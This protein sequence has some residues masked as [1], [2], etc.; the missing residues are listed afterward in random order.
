M[1]F[2]IELIESEWTEDAKISIEELNSSSSSTLDLHAKYFKYLNQ[3]KKV[4][5]LFEAERNK[6]IRLR[7]DYYT[8]NLPLDELRAR[9]WKPNQRIYIKGEIDKVLQ[10]D[11]FII[12]LNIDIGEAQDIIDM[13]ESIIKSIQQR[14]F[15]IKN[16]IENKKFINGGF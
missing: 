16:I 3:A 13:V 10:S 7:T 11:D 8:N 5:R 6:M 2:G 9:G 12:Q 1:D 4:K 14:T 15:I